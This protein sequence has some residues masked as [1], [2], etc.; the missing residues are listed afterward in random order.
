VQLGLHLHK[1]HHMD[2]LNL[3]EIEDAELGKEGGEL[4]DRLC[5]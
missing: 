4:P 2:R 3:S 1:R 5:I